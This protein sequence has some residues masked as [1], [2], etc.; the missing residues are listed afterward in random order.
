MYVQRF[1]LAFWGRG[2]LHYSLGTLVREKQYQQSTGGGTS[3]KEVR[4]PVLALS[5]VLKLVYAKGWG[6]ENGTNQFLCPSREES[7]LAALR[8]ALP[9]EQI[10]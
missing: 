5:Y 2:P 6:E 8:K 7:V 3:Y 10:I 9:E 1:L 4:Q